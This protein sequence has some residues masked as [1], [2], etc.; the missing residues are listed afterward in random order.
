MCFNLCIMYAFYFVFDIFDVFD[1]LL[2][3][4]LSIIVYITL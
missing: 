3:V 4:T 1:I 2:Y